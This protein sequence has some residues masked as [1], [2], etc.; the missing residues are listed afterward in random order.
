MCRISEPSTVAPET[1]G[2]E[3]EVPFGFRTPARCELLVLGTVLVTFFLTRR[4]GE[5][6]HGD[7]VDGRNPPIPGRIDQLRKGMNLY[8]SKV[9]EGSDLTYG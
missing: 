3:D 8:T 6:N 2:L 5:N 1:L 4:Y 7:S 9:S